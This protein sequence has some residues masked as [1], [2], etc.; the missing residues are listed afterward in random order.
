MGGGAM[1]LVYLVNWHRNSFQFFLEAG[2]DPAG[3]VAAKKI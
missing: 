3:D 1:N 2:W